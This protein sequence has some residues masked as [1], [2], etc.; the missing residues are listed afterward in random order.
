MNY[1]VPFPGQTCYVDQYLAGPGGGYT[2]STTGL[3]GTPGTANLD[4]STDL[5]INP[6]GNPAAVGNSGG[7][8]L[9]FPPGKFYYAVSCK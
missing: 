3:S 7:I 8:S 1:L 5:F 9:P 6:V 2:W 4:G